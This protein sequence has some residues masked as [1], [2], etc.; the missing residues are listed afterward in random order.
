M[1]LISIDNVSK[2]L[3]EL[4]L[5]TD[6]SF[7]IDLGEKIG[8]VGPNGCGKSTFLRLITGELPPDT[9]IISINK[10]VTMSVLDQRP[11]FDADDTLL[12]F[13]YKGSD[14]LLKL[15][16]EYSECLQKISINGEKNGDLQQKLSSLT[17]KMEELKGFSIEHRYESLLTELGVCD[18]SHGLDQKL[19]QMSGGM[20]KK[21]AIARVFTANS[22]LILL[23]EPT[24]H[25]DIETIEWM[26]K[27][28]KE[29]DGTFILVTHDRH[30][31]DSVC[32]TM[33]DIDRRKVNKYEGNFSSYLRRK[34][35]RAEEEARHDAKRESILAVELEW[36]KRGPKARALKDS[37]RKARIESLLAERKEATAQMESFSAAGRRMG[38]KVLKLESVSKSYDAQKVL[39]PFSYEFTKGERIGVIGPNGSGKSTF[40]DLIAGRIT[41]DSGIIDC[42]VNTVFGYFDQNA[43]FVDKN[44]TVLEYM[45]A[46]AQ[47]VTLKDGTICSIETFLERFL[48]PRSMF[49]T[50]LAYLSGG[51]LRRLQLIQVLASNPNFLLFDE[52]TNDFDIETISLLEDFLKDF[53]GCILTV[54]HDR[55][56]LENV[57]D[58]LFVLDGNGNVG[59]FSGSYGDYR[60][61]CDIKQK[62]NQNT[63]KQ[64]A[65]NAVQIENE[66][67]TKPKKKLTFKEKQE[68]D[69]ILDEIAELE[70]E[71]AILEEYFASGNFGT[72]ASKKQQRYDE[73]LSLIDKKTSRWEELAEYAEC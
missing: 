62:E 63:P 57:S 2:N 26:E 41:P 73:L 20:I 69:K 33:I 51:E 66:K 29:F 49:N 72:D 68:F 10:S 30:F 23:D 22:T 16:G 48:F 28:L 53:A 12:T 14:P 42:G 54:S 18:K 8:F 61:F 7:G 34:Q 52:P 64:N 50:Q 43:R 24:N 70:E 60:Q 36:L 13:L 67:A 15:A 1:N 65:K 37:H 39:L 44:L 40:L 47:H 27:K 55:A 35:E 58:F 56:F 38:G 32:N 9:G 25:L 46:K 19:C 17:Q 5:F 4:A 31:L 71:K 21:A 6:V 59:Y 45:R 3:N 11:S